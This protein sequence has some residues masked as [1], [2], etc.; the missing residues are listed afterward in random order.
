MSNLIQVESVSRTDFGKGASRRLRRDD[1][2]P[3]ILYGAEGEPQPIQLKANEVQK[4]L[5]NDAFYSQLLMV[6][7]DGG[8]PVRSLLRDVQRHPFK[9]QILHMDFQRVVAGA[10]LTV[11]VSIHWINED[12]CDGVKNGGGIINHI[13]NELAVSCLPRNI[14]EHLVVDMEK[15]ELGQT[16]LISDIVFPEG[17]KSVDLSQGEENDRAIATVAVTRATIEEDVDDEA[18][19]EATEEG[20]TPQ[21]SGDA[22][23]SSE[24]GGE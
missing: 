11:T 20:D 13:E 19:D 23:E 21:E 16:V 7:V 10:E 17:V 12:I 18:T 22:P 15:V 8:E 3:A 14:P 9:Q 24:G 4:H 1:L 2:V 6:S 5:S